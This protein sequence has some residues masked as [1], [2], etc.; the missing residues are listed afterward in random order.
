MATT[1]N[2][3]NPPPPDRRG[4]EMVYIIGAPGAGKGTL[5]ARMAQDFSRDGTCL[6]LSVGELLQELCKPENQHLDDRFRGGLRYEELKQYVERRDLVPATSIVRIVEAWWQENRPHAPNA[7]MLVDGFPRDI[8]TAEL[9]DQLFGPPTR[10]LFFDCPENI[11][12]ERFLVRHRSEDDNEAMFAKR[13]TEFEKL[14]YEI[15]LHYRKPL[16]VEV[17]WLL[18]CLCSEKRSHRI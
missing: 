8:E 9:A 15:T 2:S 10:V 6:H 18:I 11:A 12:R 13:Y 7:G 4:E 3:P 17:S 14:N 1:W 16:M 5:C